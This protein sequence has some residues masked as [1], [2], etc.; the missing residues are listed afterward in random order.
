MIAEN[1]LRIGNWVWIEG[2][3]MKAITEVN[4]S[5]CGSFTPITLTAELLQQCNFKRVEHEDPYSG[6]DTYFTHQKY[7]WHDE[8]VFRLDDRTI[9]HDITTV[10]K[11]Q[12]LYFALTGQELEVDLRS[13]ASSRPMVS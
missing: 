13:A 2:Y 10:H 12:N 3:G 11:L 1:E 6:S 9:A 4:P 7:S 8:G 5:S